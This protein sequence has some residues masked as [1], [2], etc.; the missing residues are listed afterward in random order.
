M[1]R[2]HKE[3]NQ[4]TEQL[5]SCR[6]STDNKLGLILGWGR[7]GRGGGGVGG[8]G[9]GWGAVHQI[10]GDPKKGPL[11]ALPFHSQ[12]L[13]SDSPYFVPYNSYDVFSL[14]NLVLN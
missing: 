1:K 2:R 5:C 9:R 6:Q 8:G 14:E 12:D 11:K 7:G 13:I 3:R 4:T 10:L